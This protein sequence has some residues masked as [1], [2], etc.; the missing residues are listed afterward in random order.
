MLFGAALVYRRGPSR[1]R[2]DGMMTA[3][4]TF[5]SAW[6]KTDDA[7][8]LSSINS[9]A[10]K[11]CSYDDPHSQIVSSNDEAIPVKVDNFSRLT[12][13]ASVFVVKTKE[14][15]AFR[16]AT[17]TLLIANSMEQTGQNFIEHD[18]DKTINMVGFVCKG[19]D[20]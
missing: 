15:S 16:R 4:D 2:G 10:A 6:S 9:V 3:T 18:C 7:F 20:A 19:A 1:Y 13:S 11:G 8:R 12:I 14:H 5:F 17:T